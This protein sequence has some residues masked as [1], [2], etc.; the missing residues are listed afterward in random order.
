MKRATSDAVTESRVRV[1]G[2]LEDTQRILALL[3]QGDKCDARKVNALLQQVIPVYRTE[4]FFLT[5][6]T[7]DMML[8]KVALEVQQS[9][10][11][12]PNGSPTTPST[13]PTSRVVIIG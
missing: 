3:D 9:R 13:P 11:P 4:S 5:V 10:L 12:L 8:V 2:I 7:V 1:R 6:L